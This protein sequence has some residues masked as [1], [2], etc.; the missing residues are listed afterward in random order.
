MSAG[1]KALRLWASVLV[2]V[3][4][5]IVM[6]GGSAYWIKRLAGYGESQAEHALRGGF[7]AVL[8]LVGMGVGVVVARRVWKVGV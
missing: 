3:Y 8:T 2:G 1:V 4:V 5:S 7:L 6:M